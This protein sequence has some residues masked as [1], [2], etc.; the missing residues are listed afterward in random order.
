ML[1]VLA[2]CSGSSH[3]FPAPTTTTASPARIHTC[4]GIRTPFVSTSRSRT[5]AGNLAMESSAGESDEVIDPLDEEAVWQE[6]LKSEEVQE[7]RVEL[8][9]KYLQ[10]GRERDAAEADVDAFLSD[11]ERSLQYLEMRRYAAAQADELGPELFLQLGGAFSIGLFA[12]VGIKYFNAYKVS[13]VTLEP[14]TVVS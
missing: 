2:L 10:M 11:R 13:I 7:V 9:Q 14:D 1:S 5:A 6:Q 3:S 12:T 4:T 8:I